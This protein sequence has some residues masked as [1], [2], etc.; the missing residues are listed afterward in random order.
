MSN[1]SRRKEKSL[2]PGKAPK[3]IF[4]R[5]YS[6][7][8][9][10]VV[11]LTIAVFA[12]ECLVM[13]LI[14]LFPNLPARAAVLL[15]STI[16]ILFILPCLNF[17][18]FRPLVVNI[19]ERKRAE[20]EVR[21]LNDE[22]EQRIAERTAQ[23]AAALDE[24]KRRQEEIS[25]SLESLENSEE[26]FR[27]VAQ[28]A[29]DAVISIDGTGKITFWND[30][31]ARIFGHGAA[32]ILGKPLSTIIPERFRAAQQSALAQ[33]VATGET[34]V[35]GKLVELIG[36]R[37]DG[38]E[39]PLELSLSRWKTREGTFF[40]GILRDISERKKAE[41]AISQL[42]EDL[43][44][45]A[46]ELEQANHQLNEVS[47]LKSMF[48]A[49]MSHEL[50]T[51]LNSVIGFSSIILNEW[52]GPLNEEQKENLQTVL[53]AGNHLLSLINDVIDVSKIEAGMIET[54]DDEFDLHD[55]IK[56]AVTAVEKDIGDK[57]LELRLE[58]IHW[59][60]STDRR[61]LL[62]CVL[63]LLSN[64]VKFTQQ[65][66]VHVC[67]RALESGAR[68]SARGDLV[69][70]SVADSGI[71]IRE[72]DLPKLFA[73]FVRIESPLKSQV[74][75]TGLGLYL[76][77]K[78]VTEVLQGEVTAES[79]YGEGSRFVLALPTGVIPA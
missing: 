21:K 43:N 16:L 67:V 11:I 55:L 79:R 65:G 23:L 56:E 15:D 46:R 29:F 66:Y 26:R 53:M 22:L 38:S 28:S 42:T 10:L 27:S 17:F 76:I 37:K 51:P 13:V 70:I 18:L 9:W 19:T 68:E 52:L 39:F 78:L 49:S 72:E 12:T 3:E 25:L 69:E 54:H 34:R 74:P 71:G 45:R 5:L 40:T 1:L 14:P 2:P 62:Q 61:R 64:A 75:G 36:L 4:N 33:V 48:I 59:H 30:A 6:S 60:M 35:I 73:P 41:Q 47:R 20:E 63:N 31:A 50:R 7:P 24:S 58:N 77:K 8:Y 44:L 57:G 32:E